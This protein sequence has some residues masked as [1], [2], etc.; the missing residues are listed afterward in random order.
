MCFSA[1]A[2][3][4]FGSALVTIGTVSTYNA[5]MKDKKYLYFAL[6]PFFFGLQQG[7][8]G[9]IWLQLQAENLSHLRLASNLYLFFAL[10]FW[11][12]FISLSSYKIEEKPTRR[13]I[14]QT[15]V[16]V[17]ILFGLL[18]YLPIFTTVTAKTVVIDNHSIYYDIYQSEALRWLY[19]V[20]YA[21][22]VIM[23]WLLSSQLQIKLLG[24]LLFVSLLI[25]Y[26]CFV[27]AF[28]SVW[29]FFAALISSYIGFILYNLKKRNFS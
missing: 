18:V 27:Y 14:L 28:T 15:L 16:F 12:F 9:F 20:C 21:F 29:C 22:L 11:P 8:E 10:F 4:T 24:G 7:I 6:I 2:S 5:Y 3:F 1:L 26:F 23:P 17:S 25:S 19:S 13:K